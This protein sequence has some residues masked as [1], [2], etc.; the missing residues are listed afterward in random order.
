MTAQDPHFSSFRTWPAA[1]HQPP[2][3][4]FHG[5]HAVVIG[6]S[7]S[8][9]LAARVL[10]AH[11]DR[12]TVFDR[13]VL[14]DLVENRRGVPQ[15]RHGHGLLAS[16]LRGM[17]LLFPLLERDL[18]QGGA[19]PGDVIGNFRWFQHGHYKAQFNSGLEGLLFSRPLLE[20]TL[21]RQVYLLPNVRIMTA[22]RVLS[23]LVDAGKVSGVR[24]QQAGE[25]PS[26]VA[27]DLVVDASGRSSRSSEWL[28]ELGFPAPSVDEVE[29]GIGYT[30]RLYKRQPADLDGD[31][32]AV[33]APLPPRNKRV[34]FILAMEG[35]R[36]IVTLGGWLGNHCPTDPAGYVEFARSLSR[37]D[38][39]EVVS[40]GEA[41]TDAVTYSFPSNLRRR[42]EQLTRFP[43]NYLVMGDAVCSFNPLYGQGMSVATLEALALRD[44]LE[45]AP[46]CDDV[47]RAF[48]KVTGK[49]VDGPWMIA[50][51]SDFAFEGVTGVRPRGTDAVNWYLARVHK[52]ASVD[53][54][55]CRTFMDVA[56]LLAPAPTLFR[57][58][59]IAR[60]AKA[61]VFPGRKRDAKSGS[62]VNSDR[63]R[64]AETH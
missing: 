48:F 27:A 54:T 39:Y 19:V 4:R 58:S 51:G 45:K 33:I 12:V 13:D 16:G 2:P 38:I 50:A 17:K 47:W 9:L 59:I 42:Y 26:D 28:K 57:P 31:I 30:T 44:C 34:G 37:P 40:R 32:G 18:V 53:R 35:D 64:L 1:M 15:G 21:R 6:S 61:C 7:I 11:F 25:S 55:V 52:A 41:L 62:R 49:I 5:R 63:H 43:R 22:T 20:V 3:G 29:V 56:N 46:S 23:L 60:V 36:W 8:G 14:P 24:A 10:S